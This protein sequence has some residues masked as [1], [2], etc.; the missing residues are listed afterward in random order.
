MGVKGCSVMLCIAGWSTNPSIL[1]Y[2]LRE[3]MLAIFQVHHFVYHREWDQNLSWNVENL[4]LVGFNKNVFKLHSAGIWL[5]KLRN[6]LHSYYLRC[7]VPVAAVHV[8]FISDV[9]QRSQKLLPAGGSARPATQP[10]PFGLDG[11]SRWNLLVAVMLCSTRPWRRQSTPSLCV[12]TAGVATEKPCSLAGA[13]GLPPPLESLHT[14][15]LNLI[16]ARWSSWASVSVQ[17]S[18]GSQGWLPLLLFIHK[19]NRF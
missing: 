6:F 1:F 8:V 13:E 3:P 4:S 18:L 2:Q 12:A 17:K 19:R 16:F 5:A 15:K 9:L 10:F 11:D 14:W 7:S